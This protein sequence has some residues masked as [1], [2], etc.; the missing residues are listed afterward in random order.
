MSDKVTKVLEDFH[1]ITPHLTVRGV[2]EA[3]KFYEKAFGAAEL[4]RNVAPDGKSVMHVELLLGDSRF[5][6]HDEFPDHGQLSPLGGQAT[7]VVLH[8]YVED[9]DDLY[10]QAVD[11]WRYR[12]HALAGLFLGRS[13]RHRRRSVRPSLV[14]GDA[15]RR[16]FA[17]AAPA[18]GQRVQC[19]ASRH[20]PMRTPRIEQK[21]QWLFTSFSINQQKDPIDELR[22]WIFTLITS[23]LVILPPAGLAQDDKGQKEGMKQDLPGPVHKRLGELAGTW[24]VQSGT[25]SETKSTRAR[26]PAR[27]S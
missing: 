9:V 27:R 21:R 23:G 8:L 13:L 10:Q 20:G 19:S 14:D 17:Q 5:F 22:T 2:S 18:A 6:L 24:N 25:S 1:T 11:G 15:N 26:R 4:Y 12:A 16:P 7:G 3:V